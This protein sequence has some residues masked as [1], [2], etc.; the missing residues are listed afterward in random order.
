MNNV[1]NDINGNILNPKIPRYESRG[2][3]V[4][5]QNT[6]NI[7]QGVYLV[8]FSNSNS[9]N[10]YFKLNTSTHKIEVLKDCIALISGNCFVDGAGGDG[11]CWG[12]IFV[13]EYVQTSQLERIINRDYVNTSIPAKIINLKAG[14]EVYMKLDYASSVGNPKIRAQADTT[15]LSIVKI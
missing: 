9:D 1:L 8:N 14:N 5:L 3:V 12:E 15:F 10:E 6:Q 4:T 2:I 7:S 11:Y 13:N